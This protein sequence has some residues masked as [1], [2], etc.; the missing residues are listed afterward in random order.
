[1]RRLLYL[2]VMMLAGVPLSVSSAATL[3]ISCQEAAQYS[4]NEVNSIYNSVSDIDGVSEANRL[5]AEYHKLK[6]RCVKQPNARA[7]VNVSEEIADLA[8]TYR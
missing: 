3:T 4:Q 8:N 2:V 1:M 5:W 7:T 6:H